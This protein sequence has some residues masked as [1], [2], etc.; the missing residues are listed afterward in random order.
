MGEHHINIHIAKVATTW[1][2][3][4]I[5]KFLNLLYHVLEK[6]GV[7]ITARLD[8]HCFWV[9]KRKRS[10][11]AFATD[12]LSTFEQRLHNIFL[13][14]G[15]DIVR[16]CRPVRFRNRNKVALSLAEKY[17][18]VLFRDK[19]W[20]ADLAA[21]ILRVPR[22][23]QLTTDILESPENFRSSLPRDRRYMVNRLARIGFQ[24]ETCSDYRWAEEFHDRYHRPAVRQSHGEVGYVMPASE[25]S[26]D[27]R[28]NHAEFIKI[29]LRG[30]CVAAG[31]AKHKE[32]IYYLLR[33]GWLDGD[34]I[35]LKEGVQAA[36]IWFAAER[37]HSLGCK[38]L[39]LGGTPPFL[40]DGVFQFKMRWNAELDPE[41]TC[42]GNYNLL[43]SPGNSFVQRFFKYHSVIVRDR[44]G[45]FC[46]CSGLPPQSV[47]LTPYILR[48]I[49]TWWRLAGPEEAAA[50]GLSVE[51]TALMPTGW[52]VEE[53]LPGRPRI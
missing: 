46:I 48:G 18:F 11:E 53:P 5:T 40:E 21:R 15:P 1:T 35:W 3:S 32:G 27:I 49:S 30:R 34:P 12:S 43:F 26:D 8:R 29:L 22:F 39:V 36:R 23:I 10:G 2:C 13:H 52:F 31:T 51:P 4:I 33:P 41:R 37:A 25:I 45:G 38:K 47:P 42:W 19:E 24:S 28:H 16:Q 50:L 20:P 6:P 14:D 9:F 17:G 44:S 7:W